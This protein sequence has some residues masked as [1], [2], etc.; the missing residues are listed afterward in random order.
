MSEEEKKAGVDDASS[1]EDDVVT[2]LSHKDKMLRREIWRHSHFLFR[3]DVQL[4]SGDIFRIPNGK[5]FKVTTKKEGLMEEL[6]PVQ[7]VMQVGEQLNAGETFWCAG[8]LLYISFGGDV[9]DL[10]DYGAEQDV[11]NRI[12]RQYN[13]EQESKYCGNKR[14]IIATSEY[15]DIKKIPFLLHSE[16]DDD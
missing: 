5:V 4:Q 14:V 11:L 16:D 15:I 9:I 10:R 13:K 8:V 7:Q 3:S 12:R 6:K 1:D 2:V